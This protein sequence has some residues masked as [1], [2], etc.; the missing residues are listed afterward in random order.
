MSGKVGGLGMSSKGRMSGIC[1]SM[2]TSFGKAVTIVAFV[3]LFSVRVADPLELN[4]PARKQH[5]AIFEFILK[6][7]NDNNHFVFSHKI[8]FFSNTFLKFYSKLFAF[9]CRVG[10]RKECRKWSAVWEKI[11][12]YQ[13]RYKIKK[14]G[15]VQQVITNN[16]RLFIDE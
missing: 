16:S 3:L 6:N 8:P 9:V 12:C 5:I 2:G 15:C 4:S 10:E 1:V 7:N 14:Q 13:R 11:P